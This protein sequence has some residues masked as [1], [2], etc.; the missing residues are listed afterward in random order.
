MYVKVKV[1]ENK[2]ILDIFIAVF[3]INANSVVR[4]N[5]LRLISIRIITEKGA[6]STSNSLGVAMAN[7]LTL[8]EI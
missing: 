7:I 1:I 8:K 6:I 3:K 2:S 4:I 5:L